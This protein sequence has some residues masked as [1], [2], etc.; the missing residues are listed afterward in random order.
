MKI[1]DIVKSDFENQKNANSNIDEGWREMALGGA[2]ALSSLGAKA[3]EKPVNPEPNKIEYIST[4]DAV[5][6]NVINNFKKEYVSML[7][8]RG[9]IFDRFDRN[10]QNTIQYIANLDVQTIN[11]K[12][13]VI[14]DRNKRTLIRSTDGNINQEIYKMFGDYIVNF[15]RKNNEDK[16]SKS[17][18]QEIQSEFSQFLQK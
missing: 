13:Y 14:D 16:V 18:Y 11:D 5:N 6:P 9:Q 17:L 8:K 3:S 4:A 2:M 10:Y 15:L 1:W 12:I 7:A